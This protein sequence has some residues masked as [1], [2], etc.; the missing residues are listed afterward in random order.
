[1]KLALFTIAA[2]LALSTSAVVPFYHRR[3]LTEGDP[4]KSRSRI[5]LTITDM[6]A[7]V[8]AHINTTTVSL[9]L[10]PEHQAAPSE[11][12]Q[13]EVGPIN[14]N[15]IQVHIRVG[16]PKTH[17]GTL[18]KYRLYWAIYN[19]LKAVGEPRSGKGMTCNGEKWESEECYE[20]Y[21]HDNVVYNAQPHDTYAYNGNL[22]VR[23]RWSEIY[24]DAHPGLRHEVMS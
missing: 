10:S 11:M 4:L 3:N 17:V 16:G 15:D 21:D 24:E 12:P 19:A 8:Y 13:A 5:E 20:W 14:S 18:R 9:D 22:R 7:G 6:T 23:A 2:L 1:M